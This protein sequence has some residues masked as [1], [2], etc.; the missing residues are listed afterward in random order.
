MM[1]VHVGVSRRRA[2]ATALVAALA[3]LTAS[4]LA[5]LAGSGH[6]PGWE[7]RSFRAVND[8]PGWLNLVLWPLMQYGA[9]VAIPVVTAA[10]W[11]RRRRQL[12]ASLGMAAL[13]GYLLAKVVKHGVGRGR[14]AA[15]LD[16]VIEREAFG[17]GSL[18]YP[19]GH[20]VVAATITTAL[21]HVVPRPYRIGLVALTL[22]V[23]VGRV[24]IGAHL[25]LDVIGGAAMGVALGAAAALAV[26]GHREHREP[27]HGR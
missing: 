24:Y 7:L 23:M 9:L 11:L 15:F 25:A 5:L 16:G 2:R 27:D 1:A 22:A 20:A 3:A 18:G 26:D 13:G 10:T 19:S 17:D 4:G 14:P 6:P 12:A 21:V 8:L